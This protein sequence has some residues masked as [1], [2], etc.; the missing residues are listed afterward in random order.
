MSE[1]YS[2]KVKSHSWID[3]VALSQNI[4]E[5]KRDDKINPP[6]KMEK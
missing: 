2:S 1:G 6:F 3:V 5:E 4:L